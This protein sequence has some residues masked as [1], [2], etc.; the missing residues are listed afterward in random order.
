MIPLWGQCFNLKKVSLYYQHYIRDTQHY[1]NANKISYI[2]LRQLSILIKYLTKFTCNLY[3][4]RLQGEGDV[5]TLYSLSIW[6]WRFLYI[7][8][9]ESQG[10]NSML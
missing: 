7:F 5:Y 10:D 8:P 1:T 3:N 6:N 4:T 9:S 2:N